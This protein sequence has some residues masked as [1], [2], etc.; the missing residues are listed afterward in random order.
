MSSTVR[1]IQRER[2]GW[3]SKLGVRNTVAKPRYGPE[4][5]RLLRDATPKRGGAPRGSR[6]V[7]RIIRKKPAVAPHFPIEPKSVRDVAAHRAKMKRKAI[8]NAHIVTGWYNPTRVPVT[9]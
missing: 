4:G 2:N 1:R 5:Q 9:A 7:N 8:R 3:G 6:R